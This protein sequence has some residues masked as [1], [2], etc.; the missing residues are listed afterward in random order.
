MSSS[1]V[2][3]FKAKPF[4]WNS[5]YRSSTITCKLKFELHFSTPLETEGATYLYNY[6]LQPKTA[7]FEHLFNFN[8]N[9]KHAKKQVEWCG[10]DEWNKWKPFPQ[11]NIY[12]LFHDGLMVFSFAYALET[13]Q[14]SERIA[15]RH[16]PMKNQKLNKPFSHQVFVFR[17]R[18]RKRGGKERKNW[19][20]TQNSQ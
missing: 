10:V 18:G 11:H 4:T 20:T 13:I 17:F 6:K 7:N 3:I 5:N 2:I 1:F 15:F 9:N 16:R 14:L 8:L 19:K 12:F